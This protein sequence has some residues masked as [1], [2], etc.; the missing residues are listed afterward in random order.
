[1]SMVNSAKFNAQ[2]TLILTTGDPTAKVW[3]GSSGK[4]LTSFAVHIG[5]L[6]SAEFN[7]DGTALVTASVD[8]T[9]KLLSVHLENR[10][11]GEVDNLVKCRVPWRLQGVNL[12][13]ATPDPAA[14]PKMALHQ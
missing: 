2:G 10:S 14:C 7:Q 5:S 8:G 4:L 11:S 1:M 13:P 6:Y 3:D 12:V 9:A